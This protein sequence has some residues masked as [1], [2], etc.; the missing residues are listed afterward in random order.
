LPDFN[1]NVV[2]PLRNSLAA[3]GQKSNDLFNRGSQAV[4]EAYSGSKLNDLVSK[5]E[6]LGK[7][8]PEA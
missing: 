7:I 3:A 6:N 8:S 2:V 5:F 4:N 1:Q